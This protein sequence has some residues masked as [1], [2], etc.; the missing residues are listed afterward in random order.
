VTAARIALCFAFLAPA[1]ALAEDHPIQTFDKR[2][3]YFFEGPNR[4][5]LAGLGDRPANHS[6]RI[7]LD[8]GRSS[9]TWDAH[10]RKLVF[11]NTYPYPD[12]TLIGGV[13]L[14]GSGFTAQGATVPIGVHLRIFKEENTFEPIVHAHVTVRQAVKQ[15]D[16]LPL[17]VV[18]DN[19]VKRTVALTKTIGLR[20]VRE[21][22]DQSTLAK[23]IGLKGVDNL[24]G[25]TVDTAKPGAAIADG[26]V[27]LGHGFFS[28]MILNA[29]LISLDGSKVLEAG[30]PLSKVFEQ[31]GYELRLTALSSLLP[32]EM[33]ARDLFLLGL[34][35]IPIL[36]TAK[37]NGLQDGQTL[38]F[39]FRDGKG[40]V[41]L[42]G[43]SADVPNPA[44]KVRRYLE[45]DFLGAIMCDRMAQRM[46]SDS[47]SK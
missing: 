7:V 36:Q 38:V 23:V 42:A 17:Q 47:T 15:A 1:V 4:S 39:T 29:R 21:P 28:K 43:K 14:L 8:D 13:M 44:E 46:L 10:G 41:S 22:F 2:G 5:P 31:G 9:V 26:S 3:V 40:T 6:N 27:A 37:K 19:G 11:T 24:E 25:Q 18:L 30:E 16:F 33:F 32:Q 12:E 45:F 20:S 35:R 34:D